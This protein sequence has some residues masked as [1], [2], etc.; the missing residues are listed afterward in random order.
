MHYSK[1]LAC[2]LSLLLV[3]ALPIA[4]CSDSKSRQAG[5]SLLSQIEKSS[6]LG[7]RAVALMSNAVYADSLTNQFPPQA[8]PG[9]KVQ[10]VKLLSADAVNPKALEALLEAEKGL[11]ASLTE[12]ADAPADDLALGYA[13][14]GRIEN[15][16]GQY[17]FAEVRV[18]RNAALAAAQEAS[19]AVEQVQLAAE[20]VKDL[21]VLVSASPD[22]LKT[23]LARAM[24]QIQELQG[25][26]KI[27]EG[28]VADIQSRMSAL[29]KES[30]Q[31]ISQ[32]GSLRIK[33]ELASAA[34]RLEPFDQALKLEEQASTKTIESGQLDQQQAAKKHE[35]DALLLRI[36]AAKARQDIAAKLLSLK[37]AGQNAAAEQ[38]TKADSDLANA[39]KQVET[40]LGQLSASLDELQTS[41]DQTAKATTDAAAAYRTSAARVRTI[42]SLTGQAAAA[43]LAAQSNQMSLD[44]QAELGLLAGQVAQAW[45]QLGQDVPPTLSKVKAFGGEADAL[46]K[47][48]SELYTQAATAYMQASTMANSANPQVAWAYQ[49][50]TAGAYAGLAQVAA[51]E[52]ER[53]AALDKALEL[54]DKALA[55]K[56]SSPYLRDVVALKAMLEGKPIPRLAVPEVA[57]ATTATT[58]P[59]TGAATT[60]PADAAPAPASPIL[61][62]GSVVPAAPLP[63][64]EPAP[65]PGLPGSTS[66]PSSMT[67]AGEPTA[68]PVPT[69]AEPVG[70][71]VP[72]GSAPAEPAEPAASAPAA[73]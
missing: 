33:A 69:P 6:Q 51:N 49:A 57:A 41:H 70:N 65:G 4:G 22:E 68:T 42:E 73:E 47:A 54:L 7:L 5:K 71:A 17:R 23:T 58:V 11:K 35:V 48:A 25:Q 50:Q 39:Q 62:P 16:L 29:D 27:L 13:T 55:G 14:L 2:L 63:G 40:A 59:A 64:T 53:K 1:C 3:V 46:R 19:G 44:L 12:N 72:A 21:G 26:K 66:A 52:D 10:D 45:K 18:H 31:L 15:I 24:Q 37:A 9:M 56:A 36:D 30:E 8:R 60:L 34:Q 43:K 32:A 20:A 61:P 28:E 67:P 38:K